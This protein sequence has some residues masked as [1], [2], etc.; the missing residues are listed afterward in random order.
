MKRNDVSGIRDR[1]IN[2]VIDRESGYVH[3]PAD[4][5]GET[6][7][8][9]TVSVARSHGYTGPMVDLPRETAFEIYADRYWNALRLDDVAAISPEIA[10]ELADTG[11][12]MGVG[13]AGRFLQQALNA[14]N[15]GGR[16]WNDLGVD[17]VVGKA[18]VACLEV[19]AE[20]RSTQGHKVMV[21]VMLSALNAL[22]GARYLDIAARDV[23]QERFVFGW[24]ANRVATP[25]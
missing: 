14:F 25:A 8:G 21:D 11:V 1:V 3:D 18:T 24:F 17:G 7:F 22:Q 15:D 16:L 23:S 2:G 20:R 13:V 10:A 12:N 19:Y 9:I 4:R 5:G 6:N